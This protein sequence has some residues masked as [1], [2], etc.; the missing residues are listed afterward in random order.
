MS[1]LD[2]FIRRM[3]AQRDILN[4]VA[5]QSLVPQSGHILEVGLGNGRTYSHLKELFPE[6]RIIVF[7][8]AVQ[9]H[10]SSTPDPENMV[11]GEIEQTA[12]AFA[13]QDAAMV[14]ADIGTGYEQKDAV[15]LQWLPSLV[16]DLLASGG[17]A[18]SGLPLENTALAPLPLPDGIDSKRYY[19][20][21]KI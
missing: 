13:G 11:V 5:S 21:R 17:I 10:S 12:R 6:R 15:T 1:R 7:D 19:I 9:A 20:Y 8:R 16:V 2:S 14:H 4:S 18:V 3:T